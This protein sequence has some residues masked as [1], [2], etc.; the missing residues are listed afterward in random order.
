MLT[1]GEVPMAMAYLFGTLAAATLA[2]L[3]GVAVTRR[4][5]GDDR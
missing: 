3:A 5:S 4:L 1:P 2:V